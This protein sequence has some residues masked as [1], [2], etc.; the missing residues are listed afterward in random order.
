MDNITNIAFNTDGSISITANGNP[1]AQFV[2]A[3]NIPSVTAPTVVDVTEGEQ[4]QIEETD[5]APATD[6][7]A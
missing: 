1:P 5:A 7:S 6:A 2:N 4:I 3:S